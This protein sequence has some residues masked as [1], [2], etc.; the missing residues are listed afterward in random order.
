MNRQNRKPKG[1]TINPTF[2]VFCEGETEEQYICFLRS[3]YR[4]PIDAKIA[5]NRITEKYISHYKKGKINHP[6]DKTYLVYDLDVPEM[7][8]KLQSIQNTIILG[9]NPCFEL[10]YLLHYQEQK[11][12]INSAEC[13]LK[14]SQHHKTYKKGVIDDKL[15]NTLNE[16]QSKAV[17]R[18]MKLSTF[19]NPSS[20]IYLLI[21]ELENVKENKVQFKK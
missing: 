8:E 17:H 9:S 2:F 16:K 11:S 19:K 15:G 10:W 4:L 5:G 3:K 7:L 1:K 18:A 6:K 20:E 21:K 14:L 12:G 13:N